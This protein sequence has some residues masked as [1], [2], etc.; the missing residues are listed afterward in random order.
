MPGSRK[1]KSRQSHQYSSQSTVELAFDCYCEEALASGALTE[2]KLDRWTDRLAECASDDAREQIMLLL[3]ETPLEAHAPSSG[4]ASAPAPS[5]GAASAPAP[6]SGA[7]SALPAPGQWVIV[8]GLQSADGAK[9]NGR[10]A[11][12]TAAALSEQGRLGIVCDGVAD[13]TTQYNVAPARVVPCA[14]EDLCGVLRLSAAGESG[15]SFSVHGFPR[16]H[17]IFAS[18][19][20]NDP[21]GNS[22]VMALCGMPLK[23]QRAEPRRA[24]RT[25]AELHNPWASWLMIAPRTGL[26]APEWEAG[27]G[28][29]LVSR[30]GGESLTEE[31]LHGIVAWLGD[32]VARYGEKGFDYRTRCRPKMFKRF[33]ASVID[34]RAR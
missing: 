27:V 3:L 25:A 8:D 18:Y 19:P 5:S 24:L 16:R 2:A 15:G 1:K 12:V 30:P 9:L 11:R 34:P 32:L 28:P 23:V 7:A 14:P 33:K 6:S 10:V 21:Q 22:R 20:Q 31:D 29:V 17:S 13:T 26:A 4:A